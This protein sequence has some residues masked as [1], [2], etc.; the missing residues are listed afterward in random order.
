[1]PVFTKDASKIL[2]RLG[3]VLGGVWTLTL[4]LNAAGWLVSQSPGHRAAVT[5]QAPSP[6][7]DPFEVQKTLGFNARSEILAEGYYCPKLTS[8]KPAG[9]ELRGHR[10]RA[11]CDRHPYLLIRRVDPQ[12]RAWFYVK[13]WTAYDD[14]EPD[15]RRH[16]QERERLLKEPL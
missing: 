1:M 10:Y 16:R 6:D 13:P 3:L 5:A 12:R 15:F 11:E 8:L 9:V 2:L 14:E 4:L 7:P